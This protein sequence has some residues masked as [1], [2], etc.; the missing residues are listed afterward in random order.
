MTKR[1]RNV[2]ITGIG[3][4]RHRGH[5]EDINMVELVSEAVEEVLADSR[6]DLKD[7][8][9]IVHGNMELFE[10]IHQPDMWHVL[11]DGA[12]G[13][14]GYRIT[15]GGTTGATIAC[16]ADH[17]V[18]SGMYENVLA[19]GWEKQEE[20]MTTTGITN[21]ADPLW[22][23]EIQ[24]GAITGTHGVMMMNKH[25]EPANQAAA[26]L[27]VL[28]AQNARKNYKAHLRIDITREDV[29]ES[30]VLA[31]PLRLLHM[32]PESNG[33]CAMLFSSE[34]QAKRLPQK[35]VWMHDHITVHRQ[36]TFDLVN[37][38]DLDTHGEAA[39]VLYARNG[40]V[41]PLK[42][43][44]VFEMYDPQSWW[45]L[46]WIGKFLMFENGEQIDMVLNGDFAIDGKFPLN[47]SGGVVS[48]NPIG[49]TAI[50]RVAEAALQIR[51]NAGEHQVPREV[52]LALAT[53]FGGTFWT[54]MLLLG[55]NKPDK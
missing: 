37:M 19:I 47:P 15:T 41:N 8:D 13:K 28:M 5:R 55:R 3:Q 50:I 54:V 49:A 20:G 4:T 6:I 35:P 51:G 30:R 18:A 43:I 48:S 23:R 34:E 36:E 25:G 32:C 17:L 24:T 10:G 44:G 27:R 42:Q 11:G 40:I 46:D 1:M 21:M 14:A 22:E 26:E 31:W 12:F 2:A 53:G 29:L 39:R 45:A 33:A 9:C 7:I 38:G 52:D 16:T